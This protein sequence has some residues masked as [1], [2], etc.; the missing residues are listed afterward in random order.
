MLTKE[1]SATCEVA[2][3]TNHVDN[4]NTRK[5]IYKIIGEIM[6]L[7]AIVNDTTK[8]HVFLEYSG[9]VKGLCL[10][11][12]LNGWESNTPWDEEINT[13]LD[14]KSTSFDFNKMLEMKIL[15]TNMIDDKNS[16]LLGGM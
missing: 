3:Q 1:K 14:T 5:E 16:Y 9:H 15:L 8:A 2:P 4:Y 11:V 7:A 12:Y 13:W 6:T 10:R